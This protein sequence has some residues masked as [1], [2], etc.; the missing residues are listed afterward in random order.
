MRLPFGFT[1]TRTK[2]AQ[3]GL[4]R[5][6]ADRGWWPIVR[7]SVTGAW[8]TGVEVTAETVL[9]F[10][11]AYACHTLIASDIGKMRLKLTERTADDIWV[12]A[13]SAA[14]SPVLRKPNRY[15]NRIKFFESWITSKLIQGNAYIL[16][17]RDNRRVVTALYPLDPFRV[18]PLVAPDGSVFYELKRDTLSNIA[19]DIIVPA[20]EIIHDVMVALYH[21]LV[22]VSPIVACGLAAIQGLEIQNKSKKFFTAGSQPSGVLTAPGTIA[23]ETAKRVK[24]YF[25]VNFSGDNIG[26]VA[27]LGDGLKYEAMAVKAVDAQLIEQ[28][29]WTAENVCTAYHVPPYMVGIGPAPTYNNIEALNQQYYS[30]CLQ[31]LIESI[32]LLLDEGLELPPQYGTEFNLEDL[33]RM[34]SAAK[35]EVAVKGVGGGVYGPNEA[36]KK[37]D[38]RPVPGGNSV[39]L[40]QQYYSVEALSKRDQAEPAPAT[41]TPSV[42][43]VPQPSDAN[44]RAV[45]TLIEATVGLV[46]TA[47]DRLF[48]RAA[49][50]ELSAAP[51]SDLPL[52]IARF[53]ALVT[54][55]VV[56]QAE[57]NAKQVRHA[58]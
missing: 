10:S 12:E 15:Q 55:D 25:D 20:R 46:E 51:A 23:P 41:P 7:E 3:T 28:L 2:A 42:P 38:L 21:P 9:A 1:I 19:E 52:D 14:F 50:P 17:Q 48:V 6:D 13:T 33:L 35:M 36:R 11:A 44:A 43:A 49:S 22:G 5:V 32:E 53:Q 58:A 16:K 29:K 40:Q 45:A 37:F 4:A 54:A 26:K 24:D 31:T 8:Q 57:E 30:Q 18:R 39:Y 27:V 56:S 47:S 34:D